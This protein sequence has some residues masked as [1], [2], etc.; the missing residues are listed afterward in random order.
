MSMNILTSMCPY[1]DCRTRSLR[2]LS[3]IYPL[4]R[5]C[6]YAIAA[7]K[8][9]WPG[10]R[11]PLWL[12]SYDKYSS[13]LYY[14]KV[15]QKSLKKEGRLYKKKAYLVILSYICREEKIKLWQ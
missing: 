14:T 12:L 3:Q 13:R 5:W 2:G 6:G 11:N 9:Y 4:N 1:T 7:D 8:G 10:C 15:I